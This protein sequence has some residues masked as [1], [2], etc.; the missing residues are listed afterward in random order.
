MSLTCQVGIHVNTDQGLRFRALALECGQFMPWRFT[1]LDAEAD[2]LRLD[3]HEC[4]LKRQGNHQRLI[5]RD[6]LVTKRQALYE[7]ASA[8]RY[9]PSRE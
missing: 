1:Q 3:G 6:R 9:L 7:P 8:L 5:P 2:A 4:P